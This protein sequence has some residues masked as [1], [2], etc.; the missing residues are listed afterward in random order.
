MGGSV[1]SA[2]HTDP[3]T[4]PL[5]DAQTGMSVPH[6]SPEGV[7]GEG[8]IWCIVPAQDS[9]LNSSVPTPQSGQVQLSGRSSKAVPGAMSRSGSPIAGS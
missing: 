1:M 3:L 4:R 2:P 7:A 6:L 8:D 9:G 5:I